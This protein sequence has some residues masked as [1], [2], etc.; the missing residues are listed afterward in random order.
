[1]P[2]RTDLNQTEI[3][4]AL[5]GVGLSVAVTSNLGNGFPDIVV[6]GLLPCPHCAKKFP[7]NRLVEI[8]SDMTAVLTPQQKEFHALWR[9]S[10][11]TVRSTQEAF[12]AIGVFLRRRTQNAIKS[13][14]QVLLDL[15]RT[16][17]AQAQTINSLLANIDCQLL[18]K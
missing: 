4:S 2:K 14:R 5:R 13:D 16:L 18:D 12:E 1:M 9:G 7:Q 15:R 6:G 10:L 3:V 8:K 17:Q 11:H